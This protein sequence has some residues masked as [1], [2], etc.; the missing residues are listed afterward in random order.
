MAS[1]L[2]IGGSG[3]FGK[4]ILDAYQR[5]LLTQWKINHVFILSRSASSLKHCHP[6]LISESICLINADISLC[7]DLPYADYVI[8]AAAST[9]ASKYLMASKNEQENILAATKN[10]CRLAKKY[11]QKSK[12]V[13]VSSGA[14]YGQQ[15]HDLLEIPEEFSTQTPLN[16][17]PINKIGYALAKREAE[18]MIMELSH[19]EIKVSIARC[20]AFIGKYLPLDQHFAIGNFLY[21]GLASGPIKIKAKNKVYRSYMYADDL[22]E[23]LLSIGLLASENC[24]IFNV[25]SSQPIR[26]DEL[27]EIIAKKFDT[28]VV[29]PRCINGDIDRYIP[30]IRRANGYNM[31]QKYNLDQAVDKTIELLIAN[32]FKRF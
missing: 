32:D 26:I 4:S 24:P 31:T 1:L 18:K 6:E 30:S 12:I 27:A 7:N 23:W 8:H 29:G 9:D 22:A 3:F 5:G 16:L 11:H 2:V 19:L 28:K 10:Y 20:F 14:V 15:P 21:D 13:Y 17:M 25:G